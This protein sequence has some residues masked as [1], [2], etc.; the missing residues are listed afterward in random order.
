[1]E[2]LVILDQLGAVVQQVLEVAAV[3]HSLNQVVDQ[4][5]MEK[6]NLDSFESFN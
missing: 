1:V 6:S 3:E 4:V 5:V 2:D